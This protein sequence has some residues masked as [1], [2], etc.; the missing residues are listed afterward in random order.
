MTEREIKRLVARQ[1]TYYA[2][3]ATRNVTDRISILK[4]LQSVIQNREAE[5]CAALR[6][7]DRKSVV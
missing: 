7:E 1:R 5:L 3:G 6:E 2:T 4:Q